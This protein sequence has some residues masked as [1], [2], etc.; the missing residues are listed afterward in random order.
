MTIQWE[1]TETG[2]VLYSGAVAVGSVAMEFGDWDCHEYRWKL[3]LP[4]E[5]REGL[6]ESMDQARR[7]LLLDFQEWLRDANL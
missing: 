7:H 6:A 5:R 4:G 3:D 2:A 1:E